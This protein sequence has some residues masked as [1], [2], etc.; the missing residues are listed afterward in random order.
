MEILNTL[1]QTLPVRPAFRDAMSQQLGDK[2]GARKIYP[3]WKRI[4]TGNNL[5]HRTMALDGMLT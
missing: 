3:L 5:A 2:A 1:P 4:R